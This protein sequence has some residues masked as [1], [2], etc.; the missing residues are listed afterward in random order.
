MSNILDPAALIQQ[1]VVDRLDQVEAAIVSEAQ[2]SALHAA[3]G[4]WRERD[5]ESMRW[6]LWWAEHLARSVA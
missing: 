2:A 6:A 5:Y 3:F 1:H 4:F